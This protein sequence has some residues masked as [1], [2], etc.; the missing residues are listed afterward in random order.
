MKGGRTREN[1]EM[2]VDSIKIRAPT[3]VGAVGGVYC[4]RSKRMWSVPTPLAGAVSE[5]G[6]VPRSKASHFTREVF[7][8]LSSTRTRGAML[9]PT[10]QGKLIHLGF[11]VKIKVG[12]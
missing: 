10:G 2:R 4:E 6:M 7:G 5:T 1:T 11:Q 8:G 3:L 9:P 12:A